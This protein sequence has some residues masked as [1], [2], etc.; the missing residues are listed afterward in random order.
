M[1]PTSTSELTCA[2]RPSWHDTIFPSP[3]S[4]HTDW[5][6]YRR[7]SRRTSS[8]V[9]APADRARRADREHFLNSELSALLYAASPSMLIGGEFNCVL[10]PAHTTGTFTSSR[11]L[12]EIVRGLPISNAW[13]QDPLDQPLR[14]IHHQGPPKS[15][16]SI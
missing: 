13:S 14:I 3:T 4:P 8:Y 1:Q 16:A 10:Q 6:T 15:T 9:Y 12:T 11:A 5:A 7:K 2:G